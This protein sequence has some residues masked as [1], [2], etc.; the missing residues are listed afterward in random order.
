[1]SLRL[2]AGHLIT[3]YCLYFY[4]KMW[5][6]PGSGV[7]C[8]QPGSFAAVSGVRWLRAWRV[9]SAASC[10]TD[11]DGPA[12]KAAV[13]SRPSRYVRRPDINA[14]HM[15]QLSSHPQI[16][17]TGDACR[18]TETTGTR[19]QQKVR[20]C[21]LKAAGTVTEWKGR[22][23]NAALISLRWGNSEKPSVHGLTLLQQQV[24]VFNHRSSLC[25]E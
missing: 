8:F 7:V 3:F 6:H 15:L 4:W 14:G 21:V 2:S 17:S 12:P 10:S 16:Y 11:P 23:A 1:M 13:A 20:V 5:T 24:D 9:S 19:L 22:N 25:L 18:L